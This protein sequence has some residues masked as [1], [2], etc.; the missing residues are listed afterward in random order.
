M[1]KGASDKLATYE[2]MRDF[3]QTPEPAGKTPIRP[4]ERLRYVVQKHAATR[5]HYDFRLEY[6]G[7]FLSWAVTRGPSLN[8]DDKRLAVETEPH[9][10]DYGD[11]E[12]TIPKGQY[13]GGTVMLWDRGYWR[14]NNEYSIEA[15]LKK[16][17]LHIWLEGGRM[18]G[19][20]HLV[21][22]KADRNARGKAA[23]RTNWLM[24]KGH[25]EHADAEHPEALLELTTSIASGRNLEDIAAGKGKAPKPFMTAP[26]AKPSA[27]AV[28]NSK[29]GAAEAPV[30]KAPAAGK[31]AKR[32][33][34]KGVKSPM[35]G[36]VPPQLARGVE[37]P[38]NG[39]GWAHEIK[40]DGYRTQ[41]HVKDGR[42]RCLTRTGL[43][44]TDRFTAIA[45]EAGRLPDC[46]LDTEIVANDEKGQPNFCALQAAISEGRSEDM[47][48]YCFDLIWAEGEDFRPSPLSDRKARLEQVLEHEAPAGASLLRYVDHFQVP[49]QAMLN[50]VCEM[51]L[52]GLVSKKLSAPYAPG[53]SES[54]TK[55]KCR[56]GQEVVIGGWTG[57]DTT[58]RSLLVGVYEG[59]RLAYAG[60]VG[61]GFTQSTA[62]A[63]ARRLA[64]LATKTSPFSGPNAPKKTGDINWARPELVAEIQHAGFTAA[65]S[66]RQAAYKGLR[67]D[68]PPRDV[69]REDVGG[70]AA[71]AEAP[72]PAKPSQPASRPAAKGAV[73][74]RGVGIS[75]PDKPLWPAHGGE[76]PVT[77]A[78]LA[79]YLDAV[80]D[81]M[82]PHYAG[83]PLSVVR[84]PDGIEGER[85]FQ[86]HAMPG[87]SPHIRLF[88]VG[89]R[90]PYIG[91]DS[92]EGLIALAQSGGT[93]LHPWN[94]LP[95]QVDTPGRLV[96]DLDP[97]ED[98]PFARVVTAAK[99][100][101]GR[102]EAVGLVAFLKTTGGKGLHV[103]T[104]LKPK[105]GSAL[106]WPEAKAFAAELC[107][108]AAADS[109]EAYTVNMAKRVRGGRI[110]LDYLRNSRLATAVGPLSPR[111]R[112]GATVSMPIAWSQATAKLDPKKYTLRTV[113]ALV[114]RNEPWPDYA[115][116]ARPLQDAIRKL[117]GSPAPKRSPA[118]PSK[119]A[120][121]A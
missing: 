107:R 61:T 54:W 73:A 8:P 57:T 120:A 93:E 59:E 85:F 66:V 36:F 9:P 72:P 112:P 106:A 28:W 33:A 31:A 82:L 89:E 29:E 32:K 15:G 79:E 98:L 50:S 87:P 115:D 76:A 39:A 119:A 104:P 45:Q 67:E 111:A 113:P 75:N 18:L 63:L 3:A 100:I 30:A 24:F 96:F 44:W 1:A 56:G 10:L 84:T 95:D 86:R 47:V 27:K 109:P 71:A 42:A 105:R 14:A 17:H 77:K 22:L 114:R 52:E 4:S 60:R 58:L 92:V 81:W 46:I 20:W 11:F 90:K 69:V 70:G 49:G 37:Q 117:G 48:A 34:I 2:A 25:D 99:E 26:T 43:D 78:E 108:Q 41:I 38:P 12:G 74:F 19:A 121:H 80:G 16:G 94:C 102:L 53:R 118:K 91:V 88:E 101:K 64:P 35:P 103:V 7:V 51:G 13:G 110:F 21:R 5:L 97:D 55:V 23:T 62:A 68:K 116:G 83:R 6:E 40:L 65:G